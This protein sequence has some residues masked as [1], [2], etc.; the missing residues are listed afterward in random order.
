MGQERGA[1]VEGLSG[2]SVK[3]AGSVSDS[4]WREQSNCKTAQM[5]LES[6]PVPCGGCCI[7]PIM[8]LSILLGSKALGV[9]CRTNNVAYLARVVS[10][11]RS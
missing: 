2:V 7:M 1:R 6:P 9:V 11:F 10:A 3:S 5:S 8:A 4:D